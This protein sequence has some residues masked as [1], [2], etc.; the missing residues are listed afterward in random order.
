MFQ[1][2][3]TDQRALMWVPTVGSIVGAACILG[4]VFA[5][6]FQVLNSIQVNVH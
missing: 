3:E 1:W 6:T 5:P 2:A 4:V